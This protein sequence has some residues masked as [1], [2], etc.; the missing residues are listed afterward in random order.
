MKR[1]ILKSFAVLMLALSI[2]SLT[3][4]AQSADQL[5]ANIPFSFTIGNQTLPA[6]EYTVRYVN[7]N[8]GKNAL[9]FKSLDGRT[10]RIV[11]MNTAQSSRAEVKASLVFNQYGDSYFLS[12]VW[13]GGDQ[14]GLSLPKSR[15]E[16]QMKNGELSG[17]EAKR[18]T[19]ALNA[20]P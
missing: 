10:S 5:K 8:S 9:L 7:Q 6:G 19:V 4:Q 1:E 15:A 20:R 13:T 18:V 12:E 3:A 16:R 17:V 11:N 14:Y 2:V